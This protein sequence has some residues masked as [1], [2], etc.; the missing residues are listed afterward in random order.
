MC[1]TARDSVRRL[2][3]LAVYETVYVANTLSNIIVGWLFMPLKT[4]AFVMSAVH[5]IAKEFAVS[6]SAPGTARRCG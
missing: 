1:V 6:K 2:T 3:T 5:E 4:E